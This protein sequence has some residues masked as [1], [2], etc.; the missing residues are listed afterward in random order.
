MFIDYI[1]EFEGFEIDWVAI[2]ESNNN[3]T[4]ILEDDDIF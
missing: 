2:A 1:D 4:A 3:D